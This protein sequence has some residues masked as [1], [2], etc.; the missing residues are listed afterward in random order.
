MAFKKIVLG[1]LFF[2]KTTVFLTGGKANEDYY[3][4][5]GVPDEKMV[6]LPHWWG[7]ER[8]IKRAEE[9]RPKRENF[10]KSFNIEKNDFVTGHGKVEC[11][12]HDAIVKD[13]QDF[14]FCGFK[15][16]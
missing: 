2:K 15:L 14:I 5:Y 4:Y 8:L 12:D 16:R 1:K 9:I 7:Y 6:R 13:Y 11:P 10:R 3:K